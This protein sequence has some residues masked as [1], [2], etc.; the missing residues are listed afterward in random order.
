MGEN[1][2]ISAGGGPG[3]AS[4]MPYFFLSYARTPKRDQADRDDPDRWV[5]KLYQDLRAAILQMTSASPEEAGFMDRE[6]RLGVEW[7]PE[8]TSALATCRVFVPLYSRRYFESDNCGKEWFA[9]ARRGVNQNARGLQSVNAIVPAL[10]T[11]LDQD[12]LPDVARSI[13]YHHADLGPRYSAEGFYGIMK[14]QQYRSDYQRAVHRLAQRIVDVADETAL[15]TERPPTTSRCRALSG[16]P[17]SSKQPQINCRLPCWR[18]ILRRFLK[19]E[20]TITMAARRTRG[21]RTVR[22]TRS[23]WPT[24]RW[25]WPRNASAASPSSCPLSTAPQARPPMG[26]WYR[27]ACASSTP[28]GLSHLSISSGYVISTGSTKPGLACWCHGIARMPRWQKLSRYSAT[29]WESPWATG[30]LA[31]R[32]SAGWRP[33]EYRPCRSSACCCPR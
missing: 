10:W 27:R 13:Q 11:K 30:W 23:R 31:C 25:N 24:T 20:P 7:S 12:R 14:L 1:A 6:N 33:P 28:G 26:G 22:I 4:Q 32:T 5:Y 18:T 19:A 21:A 8:L 2:L 29:A 15:H 17:A 9:F 16:R 3:P